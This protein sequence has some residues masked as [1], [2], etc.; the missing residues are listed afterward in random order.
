M[1][2]Q[3]IA[4]SLRHFRLIKMPK[5]GFFHAKIPNLKGLSDGLKIKAL[6]MFDT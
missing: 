5:S 3:N 1:L 2:E 6:A 4:L